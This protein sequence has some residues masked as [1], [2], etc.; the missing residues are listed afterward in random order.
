MDRAT[1]MPSAF[2]SV[3]EQLIREF[4]RERVVGLDT[5]RVERFIEEKGLSVKPYI[6]FDSNDSDRLEKIT[7]NSNL[8]RNAFH[9]GAHG[10]YSPDMDLTLVRRDKKLEKVNGGIYTEGLLAHELAHASSMYQGYVTSDKQRF[11]TRRVGFCLPLNNT[12]WGWLLEEGWADMHRA[13]YFAK[14]ATVEQKSKIDTVMQFGQLN[15]EDTVPITTPRG[16]ILPIPVKYLNLT[17]NGGPTIKSSAYAGYALELL[18]KK[19]PSLYSILKQARGSV[20]G[21]KKLAVQIDKISPS[22][23]RFLQ[24]SE[25]SEEDF[26]NKLQ[27]V[28]SKIYG[29]VRSLIKGPTQLQDKW[30]SLL[31]PK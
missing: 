6:I 15:L 2:S 20:E 29:D 23:Y 4:P 19:N 12:P 22:L 28:V 31:Q 10:L 11:Y 14:F 24:T 5:K 13:E 16:D 26:S 3:K 27:G 30:S 1:E 18:C 17:E 7:A 21:L 8:P 25:Y 9:N